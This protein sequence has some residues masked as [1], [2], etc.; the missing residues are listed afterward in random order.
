MKKL[1]DVPMY[2]LAAACLVLPAASGA[3]PADGFT[4]NG[5]PISARRI[6]RGAGLRNHVLLVDVGGAIPPR[7]FPE[8][9][10]RV[11]AKVQINLWTNS[12]ASSVW[13]G[14]LDDPRGLTNLFGPRCCLAVFVER[15]DNGYSFLNA[16]GGWSMVNM[17]GLDRDGPDAATLASRR[18]KMVLKGLA[19]ACGG[20][21]TIE[22]KCSLYYDSFTIRGMDKTFEMI[23]PMTY[24]PMLETLRAIGGNEIL[25][26]EDD[27]EEGDGAGEGGAAEGSSRGGAGEA[28]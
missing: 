24:F 5:Q 18:V 22:P 25:S 23:T 17:R 2:L 19:F 15:D 7:D 12:I 6:P 21:A 9:A 27:D 13:R 8:V 14:L 26:Q 10:E 4:P 16:Q 3:G 20:G 1:H 11:A 28:R